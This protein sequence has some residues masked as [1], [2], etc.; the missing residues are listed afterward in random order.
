VEIIEQH[1]RKIDREDSSV[2]WDSEFHESC[3]H[4][5]LVSQNR[6]TQ[7]PDRNRG[8]PQRSQ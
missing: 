4:C 8:G 3:E 7:F 2:N 1:W 6:D 5:Q